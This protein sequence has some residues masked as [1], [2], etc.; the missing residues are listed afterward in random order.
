M[1]NCICPLTKQDPRYFKLLNSLCKG[2][3]KLQHGESKCITYM[4]HSS[5]LLA[6]ITGLPFWGTYLL[7]QLL[8]ETRIQNLPSYK[9][10]LF[11]MN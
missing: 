6:H 1:H 7:K 3:K 9:Q 4:L 10:I 5:Q 2:A 11:L 8:Q